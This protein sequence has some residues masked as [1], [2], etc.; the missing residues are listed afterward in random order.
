MTDITSSLEQEFAEQSQHERERA[1]AELRQLD[2]DGRGR[3]DVWPSALLIGILTG[4]FGLALAY[5]AFSSAKLG[6]IEKLGF[7]GVGLALVAFAVWMLFLRARQPTFTLTEQGVDV[8]G[9]LLPWTSIDDFE[10]MTNT[11]NGVATMTTV[12]LEHVAGYEAPKLPLARGVGQSAKDRKSGN[13]RSVLSLFVKPK[14]MSS[15]TL[16]GHIGRLHAG[17]QAREELQ[18]LGA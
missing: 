2:A 13:Y 18:R 11:I 16:A 9:V 8:R 4:A 1:I 12:T 7:G 14:G 15:E 17:A 3:V 5:L 6:G 10:V